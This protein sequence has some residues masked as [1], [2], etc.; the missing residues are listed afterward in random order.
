MPLHS[1]T[2]DRDLVLKLLD[3]TKR[4]LQND[5]TGVRSPTCD[6]LGVGSDEWSACRDQLIEE[7]QEAADWAVREHA[8]VTA[9]ENAPPVDSEEGPEFVPSYPTLALFQ[10]AMEEQLEAVPGYAFEASDPKWLS[11]LYQRI[12]GRIRGKAPFVEHR[13]VADFRFDLAERGT[14]A[15]VSDW[16]AGNDFAAGV[17]RQI[18][19]RDPDHVI[20]LGD[21]YYSGTLAEVQRNFLDMWSMYGPRRANYWGLNGN[22]DMYSGGHGYFEHVLRAFRQPASYFNLQNRYWR[23]IGLDSAYVSHNFTKPQILWFDAQL[24]GAPRNILLTHHHL[25]SAF[26]KRGNDLE[27]WLDPFFA[28]GRVFGWIWGHEHHLVQY[29]D[30]RGVRCRCIGHGSLP[31]VPPDRRRRRHPADIVRIETRPSPVDPAQGM[32]GFALLTF[33]GPAL[34]IEYI[35]ETGG[36]AWTE[37]W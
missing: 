13:G 3:E 22:H 23:L 32:H 29:A 35:D 15:L 18:A 27:E 16:G 17:A 25:L 19:R 9:V 10:S 4:T 34:Q 12:R 24:T 31:Y 21:I 26:R 1:E 8:I 37:L 14:V 11:V 7:L 30:Y 33:D 6:A 20:H 28:S 5:D 36:T 2:L